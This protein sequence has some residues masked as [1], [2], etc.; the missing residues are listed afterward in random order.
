[1]ESFKGIISTWEIHQLGMYINLLDIRQEVAMN[2]QV[3]N[4][5]CIRP[6]IAFLKWTRS[7]F[8]WPSGGYPMLKALHSFSQM[9]K[10]WL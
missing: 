3:V 5:Q 1:M 10:M 6:L 7:D 4:L 2:G 9:D 8:E